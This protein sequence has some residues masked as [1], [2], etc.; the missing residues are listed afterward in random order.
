MRYRHGCNFYT[1]I[2]MVM[3][4]LAQSIFKT[5]FAFVYINLFMLI[6]KNMV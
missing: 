5:F 2:L 4:T 1:M 3:I 6:S